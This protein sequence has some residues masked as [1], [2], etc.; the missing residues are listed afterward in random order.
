MQ[1]FVESLY[2]VPYVIGLYIVTAT[3]FLFFV[4]IPKE[5]DGTL[6]LD[7]K[8]T[9][10]R[11]A[12]PFSAYS[13]EWELR[14]RFGDGIGICRYFANFFFGLYLKWPLL[15]LWQTFFFL[16]LIIPSLLLGFYMKWDLELIPHDRPF[17]FTFEPYEI[18]GRR[19]PP[20]LLVT[21]ALYAYLLYGYTEI[22]WEWTYFILKVVGI[23]LS[24]VALM[25]FTFV[26][27]GKFAKTD[28]KQVSLVRESMIAGKRRFCPIAKVKI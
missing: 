7:S 13:R 27:K 6:I 23:S 20:I 10:F 4:R 19:L 15:L 8:S 16:L 2:Y 5:E 3:I 12:Y 24:V 14:N 22:T 21:P 1:L 26:L 9:H 28:N 17:G 18:G 25:V 11:V